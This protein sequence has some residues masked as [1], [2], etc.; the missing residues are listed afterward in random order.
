MA[1]DRFAA[2]TG[3]V[4]MAFA[5]RPGVADA[6]PA[7]FLAFLERNGVHPD[8]YRAV[9]DLPRYIRLHP[10][11]A[12]SIEEISRQLGA[13]CAPVEWLP[14]FYRLPSSVT[15]ARAPAYRAG[16]IYGI[17]VSSGAAV[18]ALGVKAGEDVLDLCCAPG[19][20]LCAL[21][22]AMGGEG[23]LTGVD[24]SAERLASCRTL[25][26]KYGLANA[27]LVLCDGRGFSLPPPRRRSAAC[28][29]DGGGGGAEEGGGGAACEAAR[30]RRGKRRRGE[31][32]EFFVLVDAEC[33][34][35]GSIKHLAKFEQACWGWE[36]FEAKFL[37]P[38][39][40]DE[41]HRLQL[42]LLRSGYR[43]LREGGYLV[44]STCSFARAQNEDV[45]SAFLQT[46][47]SAA[48][49]P[50]ESLSHAPCR[51]G[52]LDH[53][54]RFDPLTSQTSGLFVAKIRKGDNRTSALGF[55]GEQSAT[56]ASE[57]GCSRSIPSSSK[58][59][60]RK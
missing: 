7:A 49:V 44:Y 47:S 60:Q 30:E 43:M 12:P 19:A 55:H 20:K 15:I 27:R 6:F 40:I 33:T 25:C 56:S 8:N 36:T 22:D 2:E 34:H 29:A 35:D 21:A 50:I 13:R 10:R 53:T 18:L 9:A 38:E 32:G 59:D 42:D 51:P 11:R 41:L 5:W 37:R 24:V 57:E 17:D 31:G 3:G 4:G 58:D 23:T 46:E 48:L 52:S 26:Q 16:A 54:L 39:R 28:A 45:V 14:G 1:V